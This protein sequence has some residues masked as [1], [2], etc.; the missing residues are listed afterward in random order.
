MKRILA[1]FL[2]F[3]T[4]CL[5]ADVNVDGIIDY[6]ILVP[7]VGAT[8][9][10]IQGTEVKESTTTDGLGGYHFGPSIATGTYTL[11][12]S[13]NNINTYACSQVINETG[14]TWVTV[15]PEKLLP[16]TF[17]TFFVYDSNNNP[18]NG[19][20]V[21]VTANNMLYGNGSTDTLGGVSIYGLTLGTSY[22][23]TASK[24]N[25]QTTTNSLI[26]GIEAQELDLTLE[27]DPGSISGTVT[28]ASLA[29][30]MGV[31]VQ[32]L[33]N[34]HLIQS[35]STNSLGQY[36]FATVSAGTHDIT[37]SKTDYQQKALTL[38]VV[39]NQSLTGKDIVLETSPAT[40]SGTIYS[41]GTQTALEGAL[42][43]LYQDNNIFQTFTTSTG[44]AYLFNNVP[45]GNS[46]IIA[47]KENYEMKYG[48]LSLQA[49]GVGSLDFYLSGTST[50]LSGTVNSSNLPIA[51]AA[52]T[53]QIAD[54]VVI[55]VLTT[56][57]GQFSIS[58]LI[59]GTYTVNA[60]AEG[61]QNSSETI[62]LSGTQGLVLVFD[63]SSSP[64]S[65]TGY[66][67]DVITGDQ[68]IGAGVTAF[69]NGNVIAATTTDG[70]GYYFFTNLP[71]GDVKVTATNPLYQDDSHDF[72]F[73]VGEQTTYTFLLSSGSSTLNVE[74]YDL[75][76]NFPLPNAL[77]TLFQGSAVYS[78]GIGSNLGIFSFTGLSPGSYTFSAQLPGYINNT[79][80]PVV[81]SATNEVK[82]TRIGLN[83]QDAPP[84]N[85]EGNIIPNYYGAGVVDIIHN[86]SW[87]PSLGS[88]VVSYNVYGNGT[89]LGNV[90]ATRAL[91]FNNHNQN[92]NGTTTY[93]VKS[94]N[95]DGSLSSSVEVILR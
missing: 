38:S 84:R 93:T 29:P 31:Q 61:Y 46:A 23:I 7:I 3:S 94:V 12:V 45:A 78:S 48:G 8:V 10:L 69:Q 16:Y 90:L 6:P 42:V 85:I 87:D 92:K 72:Q 63:L 19:A 22:T 74:V 44:G 65:L 11:Q 66:V 80:G 49:G 15:L 17:A 37:F 95:S 40:I 71:A 47:S 21:N 1:F 14:N 35:T 13:G 57:D 75:I 50:E 18:I 67:E 43:V 59:P 32:D 41:D 60:S 56:A 52:I 64:A 34:N 86:L 70:L 76:T 53:V 54:T 81:F 2:F 20:L 58:G 28:D 24:A 26:F 27:S 25:Y 51:G 79:A 88:E 36:S 5:R 30:L 62:T 9:K 77:I 73:A 83:P 68:I 33:V 89:F 55:N 91:E 39:A 4:L 82:Q